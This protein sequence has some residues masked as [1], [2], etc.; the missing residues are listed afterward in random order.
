[1]RKEVLALNMKFTKLFL[2]EV[3]RVSLLTSLAHFRDPGYFIVCGFLLS[4]M[5]SRELLRKIPK[6]YHRAKKWII[7]ADIL[8]LLV[9]LYFGE[10]LGPWREKLFA[11]AALG[12]L[13]IFFEILLSVSEMLETKPEAKAY[14]TIYEALPKIKEIVSRDREITS[15]K[16]IAATGGTTVATLLPAIASSSPA[17][18]IDVHMGILDP[19]TPYKEWIPHHWPAESKTTIERVNEEFGGRISID[20]FLFQALP[21]PHGLLINDEHLFL[22]FFSWMKVGEKPQ[23]SGAQLPHRYF[24]RGEPGS[25]YYFDLFESWFENSPK[26]ATR[27][28]FVFDF[29]GTLVDSYS[30]LPEV[31]SNIAS[32]LGIKGSV[33]EEFVEEMVRE[34]DKQDALGN[35]DRHAWWPKVLQKFGIRIGEGELTKLIKDYWEIRSEKSKV[36]E[37][38]EEVLKLLEEK[39]I[40]VIICGTDGKYGNKKSRIMRS[41]LGGYFKE[42]VVVGEDVGTLTEGV[43]L[44]MRKH[45]VKEEDVVV[46]DDKPKPINEASQN[47]RFAK[48]VRVRFNGPL[49]SAWAGKCSPTYEVRNIIEIKG[50]LDP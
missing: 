26:K 7:Y 9:V 13:A 47:L 19:D 16:V 4:T 24:R 15:I 8:F 22:G 11:T 25:S 36:I 14:P 48:T 35:Y 1:M 31:Y 20:L 28:L 37:G 12:M 5:S 44:L 2:E 17:R 27:K 43:K 21:A 30:C 34:E 42:I 38:S 41:G 29:D 3:L 40:L 33:V 23:L 46:I 18:K 32:K 39:G 49:R 50:I 6:V 10:I 45:G